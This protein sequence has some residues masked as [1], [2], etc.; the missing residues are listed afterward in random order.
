[1]IT[2]S[3]GVLLVE[4]DD[5]DSPPP[6]VVAMVDVVAQRGALAADPADVTAHGAPADREGRG[7]PA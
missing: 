4:L 6:E 7:R 1:M 2:G 3:S 5:P